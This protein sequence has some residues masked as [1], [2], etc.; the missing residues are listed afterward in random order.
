MANRAIERSA[1]PPPGPCPLGLPPAID[2]EKLQP[3]GQTG[4]DSKC[5]DA[6]S[7]PSQGN[8]LQEVAAFEIL[9]SSV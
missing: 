2:C 9:D 7:I 8:R 1:V 6:T 5:Y 3:N 4:L